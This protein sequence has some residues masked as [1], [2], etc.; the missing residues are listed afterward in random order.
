MPAGIQPT[1]LDG[2]TLFKNILGENR[3]QTPQNKNIQFN[4]SKNAKSAFAKSFGC[5]SIRNRFIA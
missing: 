2:L 3:P 5:A 1:I 4:S